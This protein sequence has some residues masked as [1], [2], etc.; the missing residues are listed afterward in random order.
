MLRTS[1]RVHHVSKMDQMC[2]AVLVIKARDLKCYYIE[3]EHSDHSK[4]AEKQANRIRDEISLFSHIE[5]FLDEASCSCGAP[6]NGEDS[7]HRTH[8]IPDLGRTV[9]LETQRER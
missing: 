7:Q 3:L 6:E 2:Q 8:R 1:P 5:N 9:V 4:H